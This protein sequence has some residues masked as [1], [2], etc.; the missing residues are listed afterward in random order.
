MINAFFRVYEAE[1]RK[2]GA[3]RSL[4]GKRSL[5]ASRRRPS[6]VPA[7]QFFQ[8]R[9]NHGI[10]GSA[11]VGTTTVTTRWDKCGGAPRGP[12]SAMLPRLVF[13]FSRGPPSA[14]S[15]QIRPHPVTVSHLSSV[16]CLRF[17]LPRAACSFFLTLT[18]TEKR[19][20]PPAPRPDNNDSSLYKMADH[21]P[22]RLFVPHGRASPRC[23]GIGS[24]WIAPG[25]VHASAWR[26]PHESSTSRR[27]FSGWLILS[28]PSEVCRF[29]F[30]RAR[31]PYARTPR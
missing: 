20:V 27:K 8:L 31:T 22:L 6:R 29:F 26:L 7:Q 19:H 28:P 4:T 3:E 18:D 13:L 23:C 30:T 5:V 10:Q 21:G 1:I 14:R 25:R 16:S 24:S 2:I 11:V 17:R 15:S 9:N 12:V